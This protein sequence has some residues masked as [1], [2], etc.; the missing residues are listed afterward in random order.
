MRPRV[1][2]FF[3]FLLDDLEAIEYTEPQ[4]VVHRFAAGE[5]AE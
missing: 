3:N 4:N 1:S 5:A 2:L